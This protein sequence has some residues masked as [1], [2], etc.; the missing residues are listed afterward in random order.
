MIAAGAAGLLL[1]AGAGSRMGEPKALVHDDEGTSWLVRSVG[2]LRDAGCDPVLVVLGARADE[3]RRLVPPEAR[4]VV[5]SDWADG[6]AASLRAGLRALLDTD[7]PTAVITLVDLPDLT[8]DVVARVVAA[9]TGPGAL[10]R[11]TYDGRP[12]HPV[13]AGREHWAAMAGEVSGDRGAQG[14]L[15]THETVAV[16][17]A[18]LSTGRDQDT[19]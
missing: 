2:V 11:A 16:E 19:R 17:C 18:D 8:S 7:A 9:R 4:V 13:L 12:G 5:A 1:A 6:M 10:A 15:A 14:Y 3:A